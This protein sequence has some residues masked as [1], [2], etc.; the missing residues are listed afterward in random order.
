VALAMLVGIAG[1]LA[2]L[3]GAVFYG[4]W[5]GVAMLL[6]VVPA[7][8]VAWY[9]TGR[10][11][12]RALIGLAALGIGWIVLV[13]MAA[14]NTIRIQNDSGKTIQRIQFSGGN[15]SF[16]FTN[17]GPDVDIEGHFRT[18]MFRGPIYVEVRLD[19]VHD[20]NAEERV[21]YAPAPGGRWFV[22]EDLE[23]WT[24]T[25]RSAQPLRFFRSYA[26]VRVTE[27]K[28]VEVRTRR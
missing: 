4:A 5:T 12:T 21:R 22:I 19:D 18:L 27:E 14:L 20:P 10:R 8:A 26:H 1:V 7:A 17:I 25:G 3:A 2:Y 15:W 16:A 13:H 6:L 28:E 9:W 24:A 23:P 11:R